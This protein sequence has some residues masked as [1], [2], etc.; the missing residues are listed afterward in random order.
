VP[1]ALDEAAADELLEYAQWLAAEEDE[2]L[3]DE[4]RARVEAGEAEIRRGDYVT[5]EACADGHPAA[6]GIGDV[7]ARENDARTHR[8]MAH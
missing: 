8:L 7:E 1:A 6:D 4:E 5:L 2:P 3:T